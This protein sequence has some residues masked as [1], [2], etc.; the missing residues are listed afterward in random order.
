VAHYIVAPKE[1]R[2]ELLCAADGSVSSTST[3]DRRWSRLELRR[4]G[5][6]TGV[7]GSTGRSIAKPILGCV[8]GSS[9]R[10]FFLHDGEVLSGQEKVI[11][12]VLCVLFSRADNGQSTALHVPHQL[13]CKMYLPNTS[14]PRQSQPL[15][16]WQRR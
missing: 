16:L 1:S 13:A 10:G 9:L 8:P 5:D 6:E 14:Y 11:E 15:P 3:V 2:R 7:W 12:T 4:F